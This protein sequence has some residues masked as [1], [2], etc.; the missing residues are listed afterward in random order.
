MSPEIESLADQT[1]SGRRFN[2]R[3]RAHSPSECD[4][5]IEHLGFVY[6]VGFVEAI[7]FHFGDVENDEMNHHFVEVFNNVK[8]AESGIDVPCEENEMRLA[9]A[10]WGLVQL[11]A[12]VNLLDRE[13]PSL[14]S[15]WLSDKVGD[16]Y[17][18]SQGDFLSYA[19]RSAVARSGGVKKY[20]KHVAPREFTQSQWQLHRDEYA[21]NKSE[22]ARIYSRRL[23]Q[24][25]GLNVTDRTIREVWLSDSQSASNLDG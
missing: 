5:F 24:E 13:G 22:F 25:F 19:F 8:D 23:K 17:V 11:D 16:A 3:D 15:H 14:A 1:L 20:E 7:S 18:E 10:V 6:S 21:G 4:E 12:L 9:F 2:R